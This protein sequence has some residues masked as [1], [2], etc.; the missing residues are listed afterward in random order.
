MDRVYRSPVTC[1]PLH[2][3]E[4]QWAEHLHTACA[5]VTF[6]AVRTTKVLRQE[7]TADG[8]Q[9]ALGRHLGHLAGAE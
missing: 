2:V 4:A 8:Q 6:I 7:E 9:Q 1:I 3:K 5:L